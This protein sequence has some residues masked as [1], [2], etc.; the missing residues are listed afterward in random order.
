MAIAGRP[1]PL[2]DE[3]AEFL[4]TGP[5]P[6]QILHFRPSKITQRRATTLLSRLKENRLTDEQK[7]ELDQYVQ[8]ELLMRMVKAHIRSGGANDG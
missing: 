8:A 1:A 6:A 3:L 4:A 2:I 7:S 5:S